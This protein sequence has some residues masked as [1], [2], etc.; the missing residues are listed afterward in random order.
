MAVEVCAVA[1]IMRLGLS[2]KGGAREIQKC[3]IPASMP[4]L[5]WLTG[6]DRHFWD[7]KLSF[8][9]LAE[10]PSKMKK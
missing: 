8:L 6:T 1:E 4:S 9:D 10:I 3:R 5:S 7:K 2:W